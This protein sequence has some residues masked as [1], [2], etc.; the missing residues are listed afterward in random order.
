MKP[1]ANCLVL[2]LTDYAEA[3]SRF[4]TAQSRK[5]ARPLSTG[6]VRGQC[7]SNFLC[8]PKLYCTQENLF[9]PP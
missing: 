4:P 6:G 1:A 3:S 5:H 2:S 9:L 7:P 8:L